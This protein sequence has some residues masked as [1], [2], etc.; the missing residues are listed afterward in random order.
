MTAC[1]SPRH[2]RAGGQSGPG[3]VAAGS[4]T[5]LL[6]RQRIP[7]LGGLSQGAVS[8]MRT[9]GWAPHGHR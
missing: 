8:A 4:L 3:G 6:G 9:L 1:S 7:L 5:S 2:L